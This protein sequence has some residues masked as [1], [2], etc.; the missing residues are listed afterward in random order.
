MAIPLAARYFYHRRNVAVVMIGTRTQ[1]T[2]DHFANGQ[3]TMTAANDAL[4]F[5]RRF[6]YAF[7]TIPAE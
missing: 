2:V 3:R 4:S 1:L 7:E 6:I 5:V